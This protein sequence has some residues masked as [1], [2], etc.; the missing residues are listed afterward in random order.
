MTV[1][2]G[3]MGLAIDV[4]LLFRAKRIAQTAADAA[5]IAAAL[6]YDYNGSVTSAT[7]AARS[8]AA[9]NGISNTAT[10]VTLNFNPNITSPWHSSSGYIQAVVSLPNPTLF[11]LPPYSA[12]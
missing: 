6:N 2:M 9:S 11:D 4:G 3:M 5:A 1:L 8:A 7:T 10:N 12:R